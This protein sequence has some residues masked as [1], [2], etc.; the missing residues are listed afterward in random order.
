[1]TLSSGVVTIPLVGELPTHCIW[2]LLGLLWLTMMA[3]Q[4]IIMLKQKY[5]QN[6]K[7]S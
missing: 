3:V 7:K 1:M 6:K 4:L 2:Y 5:T